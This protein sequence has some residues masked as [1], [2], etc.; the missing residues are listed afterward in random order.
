MPVIIEKKL[1][2]RSYVIETPDGVG[3]RRDRKQT[4]QDKSSFVLTN[5]IQYYEIPTN[6]N[7]DQESVHSCSTSFRKTDS[8]NGD[9]I[10]EGGENPGNCEE[11][12]VPENSDTLYTTRYGRNVGKPSHLK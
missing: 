3:F 9:Q 8:E 1:I 11:V 5:N 12:K 7:Y 6:S 2:S 10:E 4:K